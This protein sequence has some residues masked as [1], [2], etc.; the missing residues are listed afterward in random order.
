M[1]SDQ[2]LE[3]LDFICEDRLP[4]GSEVSL[5]RTRYR[6]REIADLDSDQDGL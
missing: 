5:A 3:S 4:I 6:A 2:R 1:Y